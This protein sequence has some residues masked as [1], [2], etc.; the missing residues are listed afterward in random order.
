MKKHNIIIDFISKINSK[1]SEKNIIKKEKENIN[2][3]EDIKI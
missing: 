3:E 1:V 2:K